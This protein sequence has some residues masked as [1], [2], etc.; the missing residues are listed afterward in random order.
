M[1]TRHGGAL[2]MEKK[3]IAN[4]EKFKNHILA[5]LKDKSYAKS[6]EK[7][8]NVLKQRPISPK[9]LVIS[10]AEFVAR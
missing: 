2:F 3:D 7:L 6:A 8:A 9:D 5:V 4:P 1:L 10:H